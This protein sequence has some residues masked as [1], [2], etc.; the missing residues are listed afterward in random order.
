MTDI[1]GI[2]KKKAE[3]S[4]ALTLP[5]I[6]ERA[7]WD[8]FDASPDKPLSAVGF[9]WALVLNF[10]KCWPDIGRKYAVSCARDCL[11]VP[12][13]TIGYDW[14]PRSAKE[15]VDEYVAEHGEGE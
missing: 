13:G 15:L 6:I 10:E 9:N 3:A 1:V 5:S 14:T 4:L 7:L 2:I 8:R 11:L 12:Y